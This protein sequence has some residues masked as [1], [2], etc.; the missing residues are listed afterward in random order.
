[1]AQFD[2]V[3]LWRIGSSLADVWDAIIQPGHWPQWWPGLEAV[4]E[5]DGGGADGMRNLR[6]FIW[7]GVLPYRLVTDIRTV[8]LEPLRLIQGEASGDVLGTGIWRFASE[9][10]ITVVRHEWRVRATAPWLLVLATL[11]HPLVCWNHGKIM[12]WGA[13]GLAR[14]LGANCCIV[15]KNPATD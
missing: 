13:I 2:L 14:R 10:G 9:D 15:E 5:L 6:R 4:V 3:T 1:M 11:A 12:E 7:K 8:R